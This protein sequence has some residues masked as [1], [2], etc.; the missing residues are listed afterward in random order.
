MNIADISIKT[1]KSLLKITSIFKQIIKSIIENSFSITLYDCPHCNK[2]TIWMKYGNHSYQI[3]CLHCRFTFISLMQLQTIKEYVELN[4]INVAYELSYHGPTVVYLKTHC[5]KLICS[6]YFGKDKT[7]LIPFG[8]RNEDVQN[9]SFDNDTFN[10]ITC[11]EVFEHVPNYLKGFLEIYRTLKD[12]GFFIFTI[13][14]YNEAQ[15]K[16]LATLENDNIKWLSTPELH[17]SRI[18]GENSVPVFWKHS[19]TKTLIDLKECGFKT[20]IFKKYSFKESQVEQIVIV[21]KK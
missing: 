13:P 3:R 2:K 12:G 5:K 8:I 18:W 10:L 9:L 4:M 15:T 19:K 21:C 6:E 20:V 7:D 14:L 11:T 17:D 16:Q 1:K